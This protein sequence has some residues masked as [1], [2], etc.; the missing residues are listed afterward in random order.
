MFQRFTNGFHLA[1]QS[2]HVLKTDK[3]LL[4]FPLLSGICCL[5]VMAT[6]A[7]PLFASGIFEGAMQGGNIEVAGDDT[8]TEVLMWGGLFV[9]YFVN[10]FVIVFFNSALI[11]C[12][13]K[14]FYGERPTIAEGF[15]A[16]MARLPQIAGWAL[17]SA[18]IGVALRAIESRSSRV[19]AFV[20]G[21]LGMAWSAVTFFVVPILVIERAGPITAVK[22]STEILKESWGEAFA[23]NASIGFFSFL[24]ML[25]CVGLIIGGVTA[26]ANELAI[27]GAALMVSGV[28]GLLLVSLISSALSAIIQAA[29]YMYGANGK[30]PAGFESTT[31]RSAFAKA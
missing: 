6:F 20:A 18:T 27:L 25:P 14:R 22:R 12:A 19:G 30:V 3:H 2:W 21:L 13:V 29:V 7:I 4:L 11:A 9:F 5:I 8:L 16:S 24:A 31:L 28:V 1:R 10:Y 26:I 17:L 15:S 23:G